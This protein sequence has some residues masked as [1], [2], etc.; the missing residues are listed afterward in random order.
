MLSVGSKSR[1]PFSA[2]Y[3][4]VNSKPGSDFS[5]PDRSIAGVLARS[6]AVALTAA[7]RTQAMLTLAAAPRHGVDV[8]VALV[9][10]A[11]DHPSRG[12]FDGKYMQALYDFG[13]S[14]GRNG[15]A[16]TSAPPDLSVQGASRAP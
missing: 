13:V 7:L 12:A 16:F 2:L 5:M 8:R 9:D 11:F 4:I 14:A 15:T 6:I 10:P 1:L 3:V